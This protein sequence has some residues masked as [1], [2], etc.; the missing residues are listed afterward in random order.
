MSLRVPK[1]KNHLVV[2]FIGGG[3]VSGSVFLSQQ[4]AYRFGEEQPID[5]LNNPDAFF[6]FESEET[7][8]IRLIHKR[9]ILWIASREEPAEDDVGKKE[10]ISIVFAN[11]EKLIGDVIIQQPVHRSRILDFFN[12]CE[13]M[14][15]QL[16][17]ESKSLYVNLL[18]ISE[19]LPG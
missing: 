7:E 13:G 18:Y 2:Y 19:I 8:S 10:R 5:L 11:G 1:K 16:R 9:N 15:F 6:P 14:F 12:S 4:S 17:T 3:T